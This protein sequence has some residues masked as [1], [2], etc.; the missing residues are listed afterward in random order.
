MIERPFV[1]C[2]PLRRQ[3]YWYGACVPRLRVTRAAT[4]GTV[5]ASQDE[6]A[7][8]PRPRVDGAASS[9]AAVP[10]RLP[11][12][13]PTGCGAWL[14]GVRGGDPLCGGWGCWWRLLCGGW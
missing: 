10:S 13:S 4:P 9:P 14:Y 2:K 8:L 7:W 3:T 12:A 5:V 1:S 11:P 6:A